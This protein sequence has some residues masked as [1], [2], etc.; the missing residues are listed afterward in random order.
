MTEGQY[1]ALLHP[2]SFQGAQL[3]VTAMT[4]G[5][6]ATTPFVYCGNV[7]PSRTYTELSVLVSQRACSALTMLLSR[8]AAMVAVA[9]LPHFSHPPNLIH[10]TSLCSFQSWE[11]CL[12]HLHISDIVREACRRTKCAMLE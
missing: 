2:E 4:A 11:I 7:L 8:S 6:M 1:P 5:W 9:C 3:G 10:P 12:I